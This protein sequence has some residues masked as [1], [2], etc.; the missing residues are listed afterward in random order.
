MSIEFPVNVIGTMGNELVFKIK[1]FYRKCYDFKHAQ[2]C[3][4]I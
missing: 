1:Q 3:G 4:T 2:L